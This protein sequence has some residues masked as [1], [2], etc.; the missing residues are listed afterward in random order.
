MDR[1]ALLNTLRDYGLFS[2]G[3]GPRTE[4]HPVSADARQ[5]LHNQ[6]WGVI[7]E[8]LGDGWGDDDEAGDDELPFWMSER[9]VAQLAANDD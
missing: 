5:R 2:E 9:A 8:I 7:G 1:Y 6:Y 3:I 4:W